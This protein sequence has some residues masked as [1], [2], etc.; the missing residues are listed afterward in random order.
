MGKKTNYER[1]ASKKSLLGS[2]TS[3][4]ETKGDAKNTAIETAKDLIVG[5]VAGGLVGAAIGKASMLVG[6]AVTGIGHYTKSRIASIFGIGM[7][8]SSGFQNTATK[9]VSGTPA[10]E[11]DGVKERVVSFTDTLK[12]K[13]FLDKVIKSKSADQGNE[14]TQGMGE[15]QYFVYPGSKELEG[16]SMGEMDMKALDVIEQKIADSAEKFSAER[17]I[18][19]PDDEFGELEPTERIL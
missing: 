4:L 8:A 5:V 15:V 11:L 16:K 9:T 12:Q 7:M 3:D 2:I 13:L 1:Q 17:Q 14:G 19:G 18:A 6:V 10:D